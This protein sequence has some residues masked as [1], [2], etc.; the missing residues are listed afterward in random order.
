MSKIF[1]VSVVYAMLYL[2]V[3]N[4]SI[5][6]GNTLNSKEHSMKELLVN[7]FRFASRKPS[8]ER[9]ARKFDAARIPYQYIDCVNWK[10]YPYKPVVK[11]RMA[12]SNDE[13]YLQFY[14]REKYILAQ[15]EPEDD[16]CWPSN[17]SCVEFF[18]SPGSDH[19][20]YNFEFSCIGYCLIQSG[21]GRP[22]RKRLPGEITKQVRV[23]STLGK[24][25]FDLKEGD[26]EWTLTVAIPLLIMEKQH[27]K[28]K[29]EKWTANF[30]KC[31][32]KLPEK[33]YLS[34]NPVGTPGPD[35]HSPEYFRAIRFE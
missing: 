27:K 34:W 13:L 18:V 30:Y 23:L 5:I 26:F 20:Y 12:Y 25:T 21:P 4:G 28:L 35:F 31:G 10:E 2:T 19:N 22:G 17:D 7:R 24:E 11:F 33:A 8:P 32:D 14:V 9:I 16:S 1:T 29:E 6:S 15:C 3:T